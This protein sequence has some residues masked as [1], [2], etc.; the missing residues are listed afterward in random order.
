MKNQ[1]KICSRGSLVEGLGAMLG[2][3]I[4][5][6]S[7]LEGVLG[8]SWAQEPIKTPK[9]EEMGLQG[10]P[11]DPPTWSQNPSKINIKSTKKMIIFWSDFLIDFW[12]ILGGFW[13]PTW[14]QHPPKIYKKSIKKNDRFLHHFFIYFLPMFE[15]SNL[16]FLMTLSAKTLI[17]E[18]LVNMD[19][20]RFFINFY[21]H[22]GPQNRS[23][24]NK[25]S[26]KKSTKFWYQFLMDFRWILGGFGASCW[27]QNPS[28]I[29]HKSMPK[30]W[31]KKVGPKSMRLKKGCAGNSSCGPW[32]E[33]KELEN[34]RE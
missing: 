14:G 11:W 4:G 16:Q 9:G 8:P 23:K 29:D 34:Q 6:G 19:F 17:F 26:L 32:R 18:I 33:L 15:G 3:K 31:C 27:P 7:P 13:V 1:P 12:S 20:D 10:P 25:K 21:G 28:K 22:L 5:L 24:I 30:K 2:S